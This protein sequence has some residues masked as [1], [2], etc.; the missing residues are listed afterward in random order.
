MTI[1]KKLISEL[2]KKG[3]STSLQSRV[4]GVS[5]NVLKNHLHGRPAKRLTVEQITELEAMA[6]LLK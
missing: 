2:I 4:I 1:E 5:V 6:E 3:A